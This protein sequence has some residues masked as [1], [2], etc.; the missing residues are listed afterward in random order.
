M[1]NWKLVAIIA[2]V[3]IIISGCYLSFTYYQGTAYNRGVSDG[4]NFIVAEQTKQQVLFYVDYEDNE[5][6]KNIE[7]NRLCGGN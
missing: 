5:T 2:I 1:N 7:L 4:A 3:I 6:I